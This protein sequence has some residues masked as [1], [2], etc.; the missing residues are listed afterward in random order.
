[1]RTDLDDLIDRYL[2]RRVTLGEL[3]G[4]SAKVIRAVLRQWARYVGPT[5]PE[6]WTAELA[7]AWALEPRLR[8]ATRKSRLTKL[9]PFC[10]WLVD[11]Q[12]LERDPTS[13]IAKVVVPP[14]FP[15]DLTASE[16][17]ELLAACPDERA[18]LIVLL[19]VHVGLRCGDVARIQIEDLDVRRR[20]VYVRAKGGRGEPTHWSPIPD[21][22]WEAVAAW[23]RRQGLRNGALIRS[24]LR[25]DR[26][27]RPDTIGDLV[28]Q[29]IADAGLKLYA[30]DGRT[31]HAL[32][33]TCAQHMLDLGADLRDV[34]HALG[35]KTLRSTEYYARKE[36]LGLR[37]A[38]GGRTY[39]RRAA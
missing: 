30:H 11:E 17:A 23:I 34:Q 29:W 15:R 36:P 39:L 21:E 38:M 28:G 26:G 37:D 22:A 33:H 31:P 2:A 14:G 7:A 32:R 16:V 13:R 9:G 4:S 18:R 19:M 3:A 35:H 25:P 24:Y 5:P 6:D 27:L 8:P 20:S 1:M 10:R 12:V